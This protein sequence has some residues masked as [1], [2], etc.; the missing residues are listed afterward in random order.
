MEGQRTE[1]ARQQLNREIHRSS[2]NFLLG[3]ELLLRGS[4]GSSGFSGY[5]GPE[6]AVQR[7]GSGL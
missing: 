6:V 4:T 3:K 5:T 7:V 2:H 1:K